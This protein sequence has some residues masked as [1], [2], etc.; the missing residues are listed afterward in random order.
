ML[1]E[2][3]GQMDA[4]NR[5]AF[6]GHLPAILRQSGFGQAFVI[7][8]HSSVLDALPGRIEIES[9]GNGA[10]RTSTVRVAT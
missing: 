4:A 3:F 8:H 9:D 1:D 7:A 6:A 2:P 5:R 10:N